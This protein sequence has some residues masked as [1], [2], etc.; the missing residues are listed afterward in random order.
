MQKFNLEQLLLPSLSL[1]RK[2]LSRGMDSLKAMKLLSENGS[3]L[4]D[5]ALLITEIYIYLKAFSITAE[6]LL[7]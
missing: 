5:S 4:G 1:L 3:I 6:T 7:E 2:L